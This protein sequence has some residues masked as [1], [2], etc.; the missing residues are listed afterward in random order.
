MQSWG[1]AQSRSL[2]RAAELAQLEPFYRYIMK[3]R[4]D[5]NYEVHRVLMHVPQHIRRPTPCPLSASE[6]SAHMEKAR[7][8]RVCRGQT[9][10]ILK[11]RRAPP[12]PAIAGQRRF[13]RS[14]HV[15]RRVRFTLP[16]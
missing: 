15:P 13:L 4:S 9:R 3:K 12:K 1:D 10:S 8:A 6:V 5:G 11:K 14:V 16:S 7:R 2:L